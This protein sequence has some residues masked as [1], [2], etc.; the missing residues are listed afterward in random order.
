MRFYKNDAISILKPFFSDFR[1][2]VESGFSTCLTEYKPYT[3]LYAR[4][5]KASLVYDHIIDEARKTF[6]DKNNINIIET[7]GLFLIDVGGEILIRFKKFNTD[8]RSS[9]FPTKQQL[10]FK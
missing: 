9:N 8:L 3:H 1:Q 5:T 10:C 6:A 4:R 7:N 2:C